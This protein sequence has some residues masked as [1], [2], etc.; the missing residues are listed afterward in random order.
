MRFR[1]FCPQFS[2]YPSFPPLIFISHSLFTILSTLSFIPSI[3]VNFCFIPMI[4]PHLHPYSYRLRFEV[5]SSYF[6]NY[7]LEI[8]SCLSLSLS[9]LNQEQVISS[10]LYRASE[11]LSISVIKDSYFELVLGDNEILA[12]IFSHRS[13]YFIKSVRKAIG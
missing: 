12:S 3:L 11:I 13:Q 2:L 4:L 7:F 10:E 9:N 8:H 1:G 5:N 6:L